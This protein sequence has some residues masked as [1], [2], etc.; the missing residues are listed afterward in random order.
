MITNS[1]WCLKY[2]SWTEQRHLF[3]SYNRKRYIGS[4]FFLLLF[5]VRK[6]WR[7]SIYMPSPLTVVI[8]NSQWCLKYLSWT[9]QRYFFTSYNRKRYI[10]SLFFLASFLGKKELKKFNLYAFP[11]H[12]NDFQ[13][14]DHR[15]ESIFMWKEGIT[16]NNEP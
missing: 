14:E 9:E 16:K 10:G 5:W 15:V 4:L 3:T 1:Q 2:L 11:S 7:S 12:I 8:T 13:V 6:N